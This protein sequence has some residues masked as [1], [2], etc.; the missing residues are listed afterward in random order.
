MV[1]IDFDGG[2]FGGVHSPKTKVVVAPI[3]TAF[4]Q[5][6]V[7]AKVLDRGV[8]L[9][10]LEA[11]VASY[12]FEI[13]RVPGQGV[14]P[15]PREA[16]ATLTSGVAR[17]EGLVPNDYV[18][19]EY[20]EETLLFARRGKAAAV[21]SLAAVVYTRAAYLADPEVS[22]NPAMAGVAGEDVTHVLVTILATVGPKPPVS[23]HRFV[24]NLG[25]GNRAYAPDAGY[26]LET[27][28]ADAKAIVAYEK[29]WIT[30][31]D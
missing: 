5:A 12:N 7:G 25:G 27:A 20:R 14:V 28:I 29:E 10:F 2:V 31:A 23:S 18:V 30:V 11:A 22:G 17:R 21:E 4:A 24:R 6:S 19:R 1:M 3:V 16:F 15:M 26:T 13:Q 8:F 9:R